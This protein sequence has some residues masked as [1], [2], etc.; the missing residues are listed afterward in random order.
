MENHG[1][2]DEIRSALEGTTGVSQRDST[3]LGQAM[4]YVAVPLVRSGAVE[5]AVRVSCQMSD[6]E[7]WLS[8]LRNEIVQIALLVIVLAAGCALFV[9]RKLAAPIA[10][11][12][13][14]ARAVAAGDF[15]VRVSVDSRD[16]VQ[17]FAESFNHMTG[18]IRELF[19]EGLAQAGRAHQHHHLAA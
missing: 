9:A 4:L 15:N 8:R 19:E 16:E 10:R 13:R 7:Q 2:R 14:A 1:A 6:I 5:G 12:G 17:E 11:L 3:T 18:R